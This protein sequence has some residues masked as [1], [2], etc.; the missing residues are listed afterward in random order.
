MHETNEKITALYCRLSHE[1]SM[2]GESNSI[3]NQRK[4]LAD[5][6]KSK[7]FRNTKF[8]IDDGFSG[9]NF[10]RPGFE[11]MMA[12]MED[13]KIG[14]IIVKDLSRL[15][16]NYIETG[17]Y[18][19]L[20]FPEYDVRFIAINDNYD[21]LHSENEQQLGIINIFNEWHA[22]TTSHKVRATLQSKA[23]RGERL[24]TSAPYGYIKDPD[25]SGHIIPDPDTKDIVIRIFREFLKDPN[26]KKIAKGLQNDQI[27][28]PGQYLYQ[29]YG[30]IRSGVDITDPYRWSSTTI[31]SIL[32]NQD[33][34][35]NTVNCKTKVKSF[36]VKKQIRLPKEEWLVFENTHEALVS[37][38]DFETVQLILDGR[39]CPDKSGKVDIFHNV[40]A[41]ASCG[42]RMYLHRAKTMRPEENYYSCGFYQRKGKDR[43]S[44][45]QINAM[46]LEQIVLQQIRWVTELARETPDIFYEKARAK[47]RDEDEKKLKAVKAEIVKTRKRIDE[48]DRIIQKLYEDNVSGRITDERY[49]K[50]AQNYESEQTMLSKKLAELEEAEASYGEERNSIDDFIAN[51][52]RFIDIQEL[53]PEIVHAF[54]SKIYVYEKKEKRSRTEGNDIDIVFTVGFREQHTVRTSDAIAS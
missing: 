51:A 5:Y 39:N 10:N 20:T 17:R 54:I 14:I 42:N 8:Y 18:I 44:A 48:L 15:G 47:K 33:Y 24:A 13:G 6:A 30:Q 49:D 27:I 35:G 40:I 25:N 1:D 50:M 2:Q 16:R 23:K 31:R 43:C 3:Q 21:S 36:K 41:C 22:Q 9:T 28:T 45:H 53:T 29:K 7:G 37:K 34:I 38:A 32:R 46:A 52:N 12:D 19:E 4:I 26:L 11:G